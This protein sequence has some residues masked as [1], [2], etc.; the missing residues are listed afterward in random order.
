MSKPIRKKMSHSR[1]LDESLDTTHIKLRQA[2]LVLGL[3]KEIYT[4]TYINPKSITL[5]SQSGKKWRKF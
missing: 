1:G 5:Q 4:S 3:A 2:V